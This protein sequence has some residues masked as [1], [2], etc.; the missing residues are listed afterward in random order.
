M[1]QTVIGIF[2]DMAEANAAV[3]KLVASDF[4]REY[5]D[6][7]IP[8]KHQGRGD[9]TDENATLESKTASYFSTIF[10]NEEDVLKFAAVAQQGVIVAV[11]TE[12]YADATTAA[13]I[14]DTAGAINVDERAKILEDSLTRADRTNAYATLGAYIKP[15]ANTR[16]S[17][18]N[19][20]PVKRD[21]RSSPV[22][23]KTKSR[24]IN[25]NDD[26]DIES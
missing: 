18:G 7:S 22:D 1:A 3:E 21:H 26:D 24:I 19:K 8:E 16:F 15:P 9:I 5:I 4:N 23:I 17:S 20:K 13:D 6:V 10:K 11:Q 2:N 12:N 14:L 25:Y